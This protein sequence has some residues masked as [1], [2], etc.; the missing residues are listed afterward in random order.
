MNSTLKILPE[1]Q[2]RLPE[3]KIDSQR[4]KTKSKLPKFDTDNA[5]EVK[6]QLPDAKNPLPFSKIDSQKLK[7]D[8]KRLKFYSQKP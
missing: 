8:S 1:A 5:P 2:N 4:L 3:Q 6:I 7:I